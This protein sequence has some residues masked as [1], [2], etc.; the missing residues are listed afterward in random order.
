VAHRSLH[1]RCEH[2]AKV[3]EAAPASA[4]SSLGGVG[5]I[6]AYTGVDVANPI[7]SENGADDPL[8]AASYSTPS[9]TT[10]HPQSLSVATIMGHGGTAATW[11][12]PSG[13]VGRVDINDGTTRSGLSA[14][15]VQAAPGATG[16]KTATASM[17]L[18]YSAVDLL[19]L[20]PAP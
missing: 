18:G 19:A 2:E 13:M 20:A 7:D 15:A 16:V 14:E 10:V 17:T 8:S 4:A 3:T 12:P 1:A 9:I 5:W 11:T 6:A